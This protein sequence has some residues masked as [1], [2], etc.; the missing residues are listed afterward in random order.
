MKTIQPQNLH[1]DIRLRLYIASVSE[2]SVPSESVPLVFALFDCNC[3]R[4]CCSLE[5]QVTLALTKSL[6][7][8]NA[9]KIA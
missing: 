2:E 1:M 9:D 8:L 6:K 5:F 4:N 3:D 7:A